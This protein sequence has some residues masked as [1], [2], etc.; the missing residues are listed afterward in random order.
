M[1]NSRDLLKMHK[2]SKAVEYVS[3]KN[4][5][6]EWGS[7]ESTLH[8]MNVVNTLVSIEHNREWYNKIS[9][10]VNDN[11]ESHLV[12]PHGQ[13][14]DDDLEQVAD[15]LLFRAND[16][17]FID[18]KTYWNTRD[19]FDWHCGIDYIRKPFELEHKDYDVIIVDGRC[20][21][22]CAWI[23][24][25]LLKSDGY[26]LFDDFHNRT[27]YHGILKWYEVVDYSS[28]K[29]DKTMCVLRMRDNVLSSDEVTKVS[30]ELYSS[31]IERTGRVR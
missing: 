29:D 21:V 15:D 1:N 18:G 31:F 28:L 25:F 24:T 12:L 16:S 9:P 4:K 11:V 2:N 20:R 3:G 17:I 23:A 8:W 10:N 13:K 30:D 19:G 7:G 22:M 5:V 26:L 14:D 6:L 27:Y